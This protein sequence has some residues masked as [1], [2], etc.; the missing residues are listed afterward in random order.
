VTLPPL[1]SSPSTSGGSTSSS[2]SPPM[3]AKTPGRRPPR[4]VTTPLW[5]RK[6]LHRM[7]SSMRSPRAA[8][9]RLS[10]SQVGSQEV[11]LHQEVKELSSLP[12]PSSQTKSHIPV[13]A[14]P[15]SKKPQNIPILSKPYNPEQSADIPHGPGM[16][17]G[18]KAANNEKERRR[19]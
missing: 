1:P 10:Q 13:E 3:V 2:S 6:S 8:I 9:R 7:S 12:T 19:L 11:K 14:C 16:K 5:K 15:G 18:G 4:V 17:S